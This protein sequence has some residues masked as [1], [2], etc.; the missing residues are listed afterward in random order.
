MSDQEHCPFSKAIIAGWAKCPYAKIYNHPAG[1]MRCLQAKDRLNAC[2]QL[3]SRLKENARFIFSIRDAKAPLTHAQLM[4]IRCGGL[5]GMSHQLGHD[6]QS[7]P[8]VPQILEEIDDKHKDIGN[9][10]FGNIVKDIQS[11]EF[12]VQKR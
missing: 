3:D 11:F 9:F 7:I 8:T 5:H 2:Q 1:K 4:K 10:P 6:L 12:R